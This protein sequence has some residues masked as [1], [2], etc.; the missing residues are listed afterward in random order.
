VQ[1]VE[2]NW[3]SGEIRR[4]IDLA[5]AEDIGKKDITSA[6]LF[7]QPPKIGAVFLAKQDGIIAGLPLVSRILKH[8]DPRCRI[9][10]QIS[11]GQRVIMGTIL[12]RVSGSATA[13][14]SGERVALNFLQRLSGIATRTS[15]YVQLAAPHGIAILDTRKTT[16]L[17]RCL[18]K[19][20]VRTGGGRNHR[21]GLYDAVLVK[22]NHLKLQTDFREILQKFKK[23]GYPPA[24]VE[25]EITAPEMLL[26]AISAGAR[27]FLLDN[28]SPSGIRRCVK[29]K[30]RGMYFEVSGGIS[31]ANI[32]EYFIPG[33]D[34]ISVGALT[35]S[36]QSLDISMEME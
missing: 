12:C 24:K 19:Y 33:I 9:R 26:K 22:D 29:Q 31:A 20:A 3:D 16:P 28:M 2:M 10:N 6:I 8:L 7:P 13:L 34:A 14:L 27:S 30:Q 4:L 32:S 15:E 36:V 23:K 1:Q 5:L 11:D 25:I 21:A 35:H 17:L 18:E